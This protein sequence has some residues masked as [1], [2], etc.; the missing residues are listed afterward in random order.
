MTRPCK[1][2][3]RVITGV[4]DDYRQVFEIE[5]G[6]RAGERVRIEVTDEL[7]RG[8]VWPV[9]LDPADRTWVRLVS[10]PQGFTFWFGVGWRTSLP[11]RRRSGSAMSSSDAYWPG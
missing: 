10:E 5:D 4:D 1:W 3:A 6:Q 2:H 8:G 11:S 9:L 7:D